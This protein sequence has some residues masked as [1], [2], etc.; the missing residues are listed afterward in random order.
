MHL[1]SKIYVAGH[2]GML[3]SAIVRELTSKGY[4]NLLV[5][6]HA[7]LD[8]TNQRATRKFFAKEKPDIV[9]LA[10]ALVGGINANIKYPAQ[11]LQENLNIQNNVIEYSYKYG[12]KKFCFIG[13]SCIYPRNCEQPMRED[14]ILS[15]PLEPTNEGYALAKICGIKLIEYYHKQYGFNGINIIPC[16]LYGTNDSYNIEN[17]HVL[18]ALIKRFVDC[19]DNNVNSI[20]LWGSGKARREFMHVDDAASA[21]VFLMENDHSPQIINIG[22]GNDISIKDLAVLI[23]EMTG[24]KGKITWDKSKP[25][26]MPRKCMDVSKMINLGFNPKI[27]IKEGIIKSITEYKKLKALM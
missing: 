8:L 19:V 3:G 7:E 14:K 2:N 16:N 18:S 25:D 4:H 6:T 1:D 13:S 12:C 11:F 10:A 22:W 15:G 23:A 21:I 26:G 5:R 17:S 24:F 20:T 27:T 9:F